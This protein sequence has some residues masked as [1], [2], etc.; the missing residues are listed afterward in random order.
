MNSSYE[1]M[2]RV[3][4]IV[5]SAMAITLLGPIWLL[6]ALFI[7]LDSRG[8]VFYKSKR[9]GK[10]R[11]MFYLWK[12]RSMINDADDQLERNPALKEKFEDKIK[13]EDD[14]RLTRVGG[15]LR[16]TS[17]DE[18]PQFVNVLKDEMSLVGPRPKLVGEDKKYGSY[19]DIV[20]SIKPGI[21]GLWQVSGRSRLSY[22][23]RV[24]LDMY[25]I[26]SPSLWLDLKIL[27]KTIPAVLKGEGAM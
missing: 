17:L 14:P 19:A 13:L 21:T 27:F 20:F 16:K 10:N 6:I 9:F 3:I 2:K 24:E 12:F 8:P 4:D 15:V 11:E 7:K 18:L 5:F 23:K 26:D 1:S 25:Y 22:E